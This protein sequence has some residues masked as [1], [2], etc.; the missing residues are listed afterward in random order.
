LYPYVTWYSLTFGSALLGY[1]GLAR[2]GLT[3]RSAREFLISGLLLLGTLESLYA[4]VLLATGRPYVLWWEKTV[5]QGV[6]TGSFIDRN[7]LAGFLSL[8][9]CLGV[10]FL[11]A[12][13]QG[14]PE[15]VRRK[16]ASWSA[17]LEDA[18]QSLGPRGFLILSALA[19]MLTALLSTASRGGALSLLAGTA[20][21]AGLIGI[22]FLKNR[23]ALVLLLSLIITGG[24][25]GSLT[26]DRVL[27]RFQNLAEGAEER[28]ALTRA[29]WR[30]AVDFPLAGTGLGTFEFV[31]P[32]YQNSL[33]EVLVDYAHNDWIQLLAETGWVGLL[34]AGG[35]LAWLLV[36]GTVQWFKS[37]Q[38]QQLGI[39]L[40]GLG[41]LIAIAVHEVTEFNLHIPA[42]ALLL[43]LIVAL[44]VQVLWVRDE[45]DPVPVREPAGRSVRWAFL[46]IVSL[47]TL[48]AG[49]L[50]AHTLR[51]WR[52]D[53]LARTVWNSTIPFREPSDQDL[54][55][56]RSLA[57]G[58][59]A[60]WLWL[61]SREVREE[62]GPGQA[63]QDPREARIRLLGEGIQR[64]PTS[65]A[66]WRELGWSATFLSVRDPDRY[67]PLAR[68]AM[69]RAWKLR[70]LSAQGP[71]EYGLVGLS[72]FSRF[73]QSRSPMDWKRAFR[74]AL[75]KEPTLSGKVVDQLILY[76]GPESA[77]EIHTLLPDNS[78]GQLT[79]AAGLL[80]Q[81]LFPA[82]LAC[83]V[84]GEGFRRQEVEALGQ[85]IFQ[86][87][88]I[89]NDEKGRL[90]DQLLI[91]DPGHPGALWAHGKILE[92]LRVQERRNGD[93]KKLAPPEDLRRRLEEAALSQGPAWEINYFLGR[94][95]AEAGEPTRAE[96][97][98]KKALEGNP[99]FFPAWVHLKKIL[100]G[101]G[102]GGGAKEELD[103]LER[104]IQRYAMEGIVADAW[105]ADQ[106]GMGFPV[107]K[108]P[109]RVAERKDRIEIGFSG[110]P[111][112]AWKIVLDDRFLLAG[113]GRANRILVQTQLPPGEHV[114]KIVSYEKRTPVGDR[115]MPFGLTVGF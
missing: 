49:L 68:R 103:S 114:L 100:V 72:L 18:L 84:R 31:F 65:W 17:R 2:W 50:T 80:K 8:I 110:E 75:Q 96:E 58:N 109:F 52:A 101:Q 25:V 63:L 62:T 99:H 104:Q 44:L 9:I 5:N 91:E 108:A 57:P 77:G 97:A 48:G 40:G 81:G 39:G 46:P 28:L 3:G 74:L 1:Y 47:I 69:E 41:A 66:F 24:Y 32:T 22:R 59:A 27:V 26:L 61:A 23:Q 13:I 89:S 73:G 53:S 64:N 105:T 54:L 51:A 79:A 38:P 30:M 42:N 83:L 93:L 85:K 111:P 10:G 106:S 115:K 16:P 21:M 33:T 11:W 88:N 94:V 36:S 12:H 92:A 43:S 113:D 20:F 60:Y 67:L 98:L 87:K 95:A 71:F 19:L 7:H 82:G 56:A 35:G 70:P 78:R 90:L 6:A 37:R 45:S 29:A 86:D 15:T 112:A 55:K 76:A 107:W 4:L 102:K 14:R 34:L